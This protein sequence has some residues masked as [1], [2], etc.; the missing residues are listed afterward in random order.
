ML[1]LRG[2]AFQADVAIA[3]FARFAGLIIAKVFSCLRG[4]VM[5][6]RVITPLPAHG[7]LIG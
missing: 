1:A 5:V 4:E 2:H 7:N 3:G 6:I